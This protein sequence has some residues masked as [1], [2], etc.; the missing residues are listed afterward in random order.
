MDVPKV[1][2]AFA[3]S[4]LAVGVVACGGSTT[5]KPAAAPSAAQRL[6][7][8]VTG[9]DARIGASEVRGSGIVI[10]ARRGLVV[11]A[12]HTVWG[13]RTLKVSTAVGVLHG[14]IVARAPCDDLAVVQLTPGI[15]GLATLPVAPDGAPARGQLLRSVGRR[16]TF[17]SAG[18]M[19]SLPV[20]SIGALG[21]VRVD[22]RLPS[23]S[24]VRLD[25]PLVPEVIGGPVLDARGRLVGMAQAPGV[26]IPW[27]Q[28]RERLRE[29]KPGARSVYVGW[30]GQYRC[31]G[32]QHAYAR[33]THPGFRALDARLNARV[34]ATR[35]PG[36]EGVGG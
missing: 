10:D 30:A 22:P 29:L 33:A 13:A 1:R 27:S 34:A 5:V 7:L 17:S 25:S 16:G 11:T 24:A 31:V 12:A 32:A 23:L 4:A 14:R 20:R 6:E 8:A 21:Q 28:I 3:F 35:L 15:P 26:V 36:T 9:V 19:A 18:A 2:S